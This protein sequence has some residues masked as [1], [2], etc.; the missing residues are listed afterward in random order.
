MGSGVFPALLTICFVISV[1]SYVSTLCS[2]QAGGTSAAV[3]RKVRRRTLL[4][5][6]NFF[7]TY[8]PFGLS[9]ALVPSSERQTQHIWIT[10]GLVFRSLNGFLNT[11]TYASIICGPLC[12]S[13]S[14]NREQTLQPQQAE[15][16]EDPLGFASFHVRFEEF[17]EFNDSDPQALP[18]WMSHC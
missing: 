7:I 14:A 13:R 16:E 3:G 1:G 11:L 5:S 8:G 10:V 2:A 15:E 12:G 6:L 4:Y 9:F 17:N 18:E